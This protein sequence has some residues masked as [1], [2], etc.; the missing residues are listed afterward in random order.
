M[1]WCQHLYGTNSLNSAD[2]PL[3]NIYTNKRAF[4]N[5][6]GFFYSICVISFI[7]GK[8]LSS[9]KFHDFAVIA[10]TYEL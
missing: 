2:A 7:F 10:I 8:L 5:E 1:H 9:M 6:G 4:N 3:S